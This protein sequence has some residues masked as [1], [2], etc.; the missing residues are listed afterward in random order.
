ME[1]LLIGLAIGLGIALLFGAGA[2]VNHG[3]EARALRKHVC[4]IVTAEDHRNEGARLL[5]KA[6]YSNSKE[7]SKYLRNEAYVHFRYADMIEHGPYKR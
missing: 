3:L 2:G 6:I 5:H 7:Y 1:Y 4:S